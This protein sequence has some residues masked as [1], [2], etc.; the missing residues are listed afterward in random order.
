MR[1]AF[2]LVAA[3]AC[4]LLIQC[5]TSGRFENFITTKADKL[6]DGSRELRFVSYNIPNL[7]YIEDY[8][9]FD[10]PSPW[11]LPTEFEIRDALKAIKMD[12]GKVA[13]VYTFQS[14]G[15]GNRK[16]LSG[17]WRDRV[18]LMKEH[19]ELW[20]KYFKLQMKKAL[21]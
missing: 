14:A 21:G 20:I 11:R 4:I 18:N 16:I 5:G 10:S 15:R 1:R 12:G 13:R 2:Q 19:L 17:M 8:F 9:Q 3:T 6:M 7:H